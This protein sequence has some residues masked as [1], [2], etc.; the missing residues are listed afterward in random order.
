MSEK[1]TRD[2]VRHVASLARL[3]LT[4]TD[5]IALTDQMNAIL[6]YMDTLNQLDT[7]EIPPTT[8]AIQLQ[9]VFRADEVHSS[10]DRG[11][12]LANAPETDRVSFVVPKVI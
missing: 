3:E 2:E 11:D 9:N 4:E 6:T 10:L 5:E 12:A 8:H 1:I 7:S